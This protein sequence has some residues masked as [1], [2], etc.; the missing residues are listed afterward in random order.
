MLSTSY[1]LQSFEYAIKT[2]CSRSDFADCSRVDAVQGFKAGGFRFLGCFPVHDYDAAVE[3]KEAKSA[4]ESQ[5][6]HDNYRALSQAIFESRCLPSPLAVASPIMRSMAYLAQDTWLKTS[7]RQRGG[8]RQRTREAR[9]ALLQVAPAQWRRLRVFRAS[10]GAGGACSVPR[11]STRRT[12]GVRSPRTGTLAALAR[13]A[14]RVRRP[15]PAASVPRPAQR[16]RRVCLVPRGAGG[17][18]A[19]VRDNEADK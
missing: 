13:P 11:L 8:K 1:S 18:C 4:R 14:A 7:K 19:G 5:L 17:E 10:R 16:R 12:G 3:S 9:A 6:P 15:A 2:I